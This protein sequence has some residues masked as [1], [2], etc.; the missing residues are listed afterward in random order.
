MVLTATPIPRTLALSFY[1]DLDITTIRTLPPG[2]S[3]VRTSI[4]T[5]EEKDELYSFLKK[6]IEMGGQIY[7]VLPLI[8][9]SE[10][11][12]LKNAVSTTELLKKR[13]PDKNV[14][15]LHGGL[16]SE[17]KDSIMDLF[18]RREIDIL[19]STTVI[20][21]GVDVPNASIMVIENAER[22]GLSQ[23]HQLRGRVGRGERKSYCFLATEK[24]YLNRSID[25]FKTIQRRLNAIVNTTDGFRLAE[26]DL[27]IRGPGELLGTKQAGLPT[28][29]Y[30]D[31]S[32]DFELL[33]LARDEALTILKED[34]GLNKPEHTKLK[35]EWERFKKYA[36]AS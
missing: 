12:D 27:S 9:E 24:K 14:G 13:F 15:L 34:P 2:R 18:K 32:R 28:F 4:V 22:F 29:R 35:T 6:E 33:T 26:E 30:A 20:E 1:G 19:V 11:V 16:R 8:E 7:V 5:E 21:V 3:P 23:L 31:I 17:E 10:K 25:A 36:S